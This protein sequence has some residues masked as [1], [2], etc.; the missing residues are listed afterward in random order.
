MSGQPNQVGTD[1]DIPLLLVCT[2]HHDDMGF[3]DKGLA[4]NVREEYTFRNEMLIPL[5][6]DLVNHDV[7]YQATSE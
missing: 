3:G 5:F 6:N 1:I 2:K 7:T 4:L